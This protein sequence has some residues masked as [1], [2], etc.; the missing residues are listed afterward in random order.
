MVP[1]K[2]IFLK[3]LVNF[4]QYNSK[5]EKAG[6]NTA[7]TRWFKLYFKNHKLYVYRKNLVVNILNTLNN[8]IVVRFFLQFSIV[9]TAKYKYYEERRDIAYIILIISGAKIQRPKNKKIKKEFY[10]YP[11]YIISSHSWDVLYLWNAAY[12]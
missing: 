12:F 1:I 10:M 4:S 6:N 8:L 3:I 11:I 2:I 7:Y 5:W 9:I